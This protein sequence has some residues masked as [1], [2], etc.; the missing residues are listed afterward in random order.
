MGIINNLTTVLLILDTLGMVW[1]VT[2]NGCTLQT[3]KEKHERSYPGASNQQEKCQLVNEY[4]QCVNVNTRKDCSETD[5]EKSNSTVIGLQGVLNCNTASTTS[6]ILAWI[7]C[8]VTTT[9]LRF[10]Y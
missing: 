9:S 3:C 6:T 8:L 7:A 4:A 5:I 2:E 1:S 10:I